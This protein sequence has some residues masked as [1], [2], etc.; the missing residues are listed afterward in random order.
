MKIEREIKKKIASD[1]LNAFPQ[2][3]AYTQNKLYKILGCCVVGIE[4]IN[5]PKSDEYS[6]HFT[7]YSMW[8]RDPKA[9]LDRSSLLEQILNRKGL[10]FSIPYSKHEYYVGEAIECVKKQVRISL[11][12]DVTLNA[13]F[14]LVD[15]CFDDILVRSSSA[16][17][18]RLLELKFYSALYLGAH[19]QIQDVLMEIEQKRKNWNM[20]L[21]EM[22]FGDYEH[23]LRELNKDRN[24][25]QEFF[26]QIET[27]KLRTKIARLQFS[28]FIK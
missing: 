10:Q 15:G 1:W 8:E 13:W 19:E 17:Q 18:A 27:N 3:S 21:F 6:P 26:I 16:Q 23:W 5:L 14:K 28:E 22:W 2:L 9:F 12:G 7:V 25:S 24:N 11:N 4:L 20:G